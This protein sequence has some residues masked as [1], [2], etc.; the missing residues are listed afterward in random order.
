MIGSVIPTGDVLLPTVIGGDLGCGM[1]AVALPLTV[2][3]IT[4]ALPRLAQLFR[5][6]I[7]AWAQ[8]QIPR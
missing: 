7:P 3:G 6:R 4:P 1:T 2:D 5:E 8:A